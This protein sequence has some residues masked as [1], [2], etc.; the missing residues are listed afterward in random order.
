LFENLEEKA[1]NSV[2]AKALRERL[3]NVAGFECVSAPM[4]MRN[5]K[6]AVVYYLYFAS[7]DRT[8]AKVVEDIFRRY[9]TA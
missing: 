8:G 4:P 2:I 9:R 1:S 7:P 3:R 5:S 6:G